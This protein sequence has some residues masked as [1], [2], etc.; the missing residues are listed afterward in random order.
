MPSAAK[1]LRVGISGAGIGGLTLA[2]TLSQYP[3]IDVDLFEASKSLQ[4]VGAGVAVF[5]RPWKILRLLG[6]DQELLKTCDVKPKEGPGQATRSPMPQAK[7]YQCLQSSIA[8][9][10]SLWAYRF[11][12]SSPM[13]RSMITLHRAEFQSALLGRLPKTCR[14]HYSKRLRS[15]DQQQSGP[16][17]LAFED[18]SRATCDVLVGADGLKSATRAALLTERVSWMQSQGRPDEAADAAEC[19][20]PWWSGQIA[21]RAVIPAERLRKVSPGHPALTQPLQYLGKRGFVMAYPISQGKMVNFAAFTMRH[22]LENTKYDAPW[23]GPADKSH[24]AGLFADWE[25]DVQALVHC[26]ENP[27]S[28]AV[29]TVKPLRSFVCGRVVLI[30]DA[31]HAMTPQQGQVLALEDAYILGL[32]LGHSSTNIHTLGRSLNAFDQVRRPRAQQVARVSRLAAR[33]FTFEIDGVGVDFSADFGHPAAGSNPVGWETLQRLHH[34]VVKNWEW[35][36]NTSVDESIQEALSM[37]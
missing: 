5:P 14:I 19:I 16:I 4:E 20:E 37:L 31:A 36:W 15:F 21:Y 29:H 32:L 10:I 34:E 9:A 17:E 12:R 30:G 2:L 33:Y 23:M 35:A 13:A 1:R 6:V 3:D 8:K 27:L 25:P 11:R 28:W 18:G 22:D 7:V 24:F 26:V